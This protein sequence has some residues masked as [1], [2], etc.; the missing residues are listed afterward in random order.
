MAFGTIYFIWR[1]HSHWR[2]LQPPKA[3]NI[4]VQRKIPLHQRIPSV[5]ARVQLVNK[6][7]VRSYPH[8]RYIYQISFAKSEASSDRSTCS[9]KPKF[10]ILIG[11]VV[12]V[13]WHINLC[14]LSNT[15][16][17]FIQ[18]SVLFQTIQ[19]GTSTRFNCQ[20]HFYFNQF[21]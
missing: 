3:I 6:N 1:S 2:G 11:L 21:S 15:K 9:L 7:L 19:F 10:V 18:T 13:S 8:V 16:S 20:K 4:H 14:R 5:L 17:I 12:W